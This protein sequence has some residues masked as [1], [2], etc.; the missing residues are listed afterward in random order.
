MKLRE[1]LHLGFISTWLILSPSINWVISSTKAQTQQVSNLWKINNNWLC[2][3]NYI[4]DPIF[5]VHIKDPLLN[6]NFCS[7]F[8]ESDD[9]LRQKLERV[10]WNNNNRVLIPNLSDK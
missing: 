4:N 3:K 6:Y 10:D 7:D 1:I 2:I 8:T 9:L 5:L